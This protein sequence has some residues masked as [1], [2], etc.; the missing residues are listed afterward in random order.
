VEHALGYRP[1]Q[2]RLSQLEGGPCRFLVAACD[3]RLDL[4][5]KSAHAA[6]PSAIN[7]RALGGLPDALFRRFVISHAVRRDPKTALISGPR[8]RGQHHAIRWRSF[9]HSQIGA[10]AGRE[11]QVRVNKVGENAPSGVGMRDSRGAARRAV[12][13]AVRV[14]V[15]WGVHG[16]AGLSVFTFSRSWRDLETAEEVCPV[17]ADHERRRSTPRP[18]VADRPAELQLSGQVGASRL[19]LNSHPCVLCS[20][21]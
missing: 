7:G 21:V 16:D 17:L 2:L 13:V 3:R 15:S 8:P 18:L 12:T 1:M 6:H 9:W 20:L 5:D 19:E 4:F 11:A 14:A 10:P